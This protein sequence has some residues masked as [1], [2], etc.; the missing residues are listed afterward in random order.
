MTKISAI[1]LVAGLSSRM[2]GPNK[3]LLPFKGK[4]IV[5]QTYDQLC[6]SRVDEIIVVTGRDQQ[7]VMDQL[8][9]KP[10]SKFVHNE[11]YTCGM[12]SSI[13]KGVESASGNAF[14]IC[15]GDMPW[16]DT[17]DYNKLLERFQAQFS[18]DNRVILVPKANGKRGNPVIFSSSYREAIVSHSELNGCKRLIQDNSDHLIEFTTDNE[19]HQRD[20][21]TPEEYDQL[22]P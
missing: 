5:Q 21:D 19:A 17:S 15:L 12:T 4:S 6:H 10:T 8:D 22:N 18:I 1:L 14:M 3:L 9:L 11:A 16:L 20:I 2:K 7:R 13:Q